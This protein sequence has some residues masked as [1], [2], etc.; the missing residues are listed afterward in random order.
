MPKKG[1]VAEPGLAG[2]APGMGAIMIAPFSVCHQVSKWG[3]DCGR[4]SRDTTSTL[5][6]LSVLQ[7]CR[8]GELIE[9][10]FF[11]MLVSPLDEG[12][13]GRRRGVEDADSMVV[14]D[15]PETE[16]SGQL[17]APSYMSTVVPFCSGPRRRKSGRYPANVRG[18]PIDVVVAQVENVFGGEVG[19]HRVAAGGV[20]RPLGLPEEPEV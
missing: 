16:K 20:D 19:L 12:A 14:H 11:H 17:G 4:S 18:A 8:A 10:V 3:S 1:R 13:D 15:L 2:T 9:P 7:P 6:D 5:E